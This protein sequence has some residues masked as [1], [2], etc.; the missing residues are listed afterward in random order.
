MPRDY[1]LEIVKDGKVIK[2]PD[3]NH[4][5]QRIREME[6]DGHVFD[7]SDLWKKVKKANQ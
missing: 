2:V 6:W 7:M 1:E 4:E 3:S 5:S